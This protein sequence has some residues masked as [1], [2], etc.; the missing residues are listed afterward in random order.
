MGR[1]CVEQEANG[2]ECGN[3]CVGI[4]ADV[5]KLDEKIENDRYEAM[6][7][8]Y[9]EYKRQVVKNIG[10]NGSNFKTAF[11]RFFSVIT[12]FTIQF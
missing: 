6:V 5:G 8:K 3:S 4:Y 1:E 2:Q 11:G 12:I 7:A 9:R 10:F